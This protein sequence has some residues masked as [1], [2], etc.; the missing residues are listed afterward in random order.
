[1][2]HAPFTKQ[3]YTDARSFSLADFGT[4]GYEQRL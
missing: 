4:Q 2:K 3:P 1:M